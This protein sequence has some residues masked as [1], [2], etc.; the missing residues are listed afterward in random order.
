M[1][2]SYQNKMLVLTNCMNVLSSSFTSM[3]SFLNI[4]SVR[5]KINQRKIL[6]LLSK[7]N[8]FNK[9]RKTKRNSPKS[10]VRPGQTS[11]WWDKFEINIK[12]PEEWKENVHMSKESLYKLCDELHI[13]LEKQKTQFRDPISVE[14]Q[15]ACTLYYSA[16]EG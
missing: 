3:Q 15:V 16:D 14:K 6:F 2:T 5:K 11:S 7:I 9:K 8:Q 13:Y 12:L 1:Y 4:V 10:W